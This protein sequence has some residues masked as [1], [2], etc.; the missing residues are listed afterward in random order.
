MRRSRRTE[1]VERAVA[2]ANLSLQGLIGRATEPLWLA[3]VDANVVVSGLVGSPTAASRAILEAAVG[4]LF[5]PLVS[6]ELLLEVADVL[7]RPK[8]GWSLERIDNALGPVLAA[9]RVL[10]LAPDDP[11][12]AAFVGDEDDVYLIRTAEATH[13]YPDLADH[14]SRF[15]VSHN[16]KHLPSGRNWADFRCVSPTDFWRELKGATTPN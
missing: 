12:Y 9:A 2:Q 3:V 14:R 13:L 4:H 15:I 5:L 10:D 1:P 16:R 8:F 11:R 6:E 7:Q